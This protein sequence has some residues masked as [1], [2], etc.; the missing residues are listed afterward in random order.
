MDI[1]KEFF[2]KNLYFWSTLVADQ[3]NV[4]SRY[5]FVRIYK[6]L[7]SCQVSL[8]IRTNSNLIWTINISWSSLASLPCAETCARPAK[9]NLY[10]RLTAWEKPGGRKFIFCTVVTVRYPV[11]ISIPS[12]YIYFYK[13]GK[14]T[15]PLPTGFLSMGSVWNSVIYRNC[16]DLVHILFSVVHLLLVTIRISE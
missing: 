5:C 6:V 13:A 11:R 2:R 16:C 1:V 4:E 14:N 3:L 10:L 15:N 12:P 8:S 9:Q 7:E